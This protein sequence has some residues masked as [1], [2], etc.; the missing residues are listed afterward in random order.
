MTRERAINLR[1]G[2]PLTIDEPADGELLV[3]VCREQSTGQLIVQVNVPGFSFI[4]TTDISTTQ[5]GVNAARQFLD[6]MGF[7][8]KVWWQTS[9]AGKPSLE[10]HI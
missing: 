6:V 9:L 3:L 5:D 8:G 4:L 1:P 10:P 2:T 7:S